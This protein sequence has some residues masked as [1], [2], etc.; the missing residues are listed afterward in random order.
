MVFVIETPASMKV[1]QYLK[2]RKGCEDEK[3]TQR[4]RH[5]ELMSK[6][7]ERK[8]PRIDEVADISKGDE[9]PPSLSPTERPKP[10]SSLCASL[11]APVEAA[12]GTLDGPRFLKK[13]LPRYPLLARR[14]GKEG[15][16]LLRLTIDEKGRLIKC[17]VVKGAGYGFE[18]AAI[19]AVKRSKFL[20]A[21]RKGRPIS[22]RALLPIKFVIRR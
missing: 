9:Q 19:K 22:C 6:K 18:E 11:G 10:Y 20:P 17:E 13:V 21:R 5:T 7:L 14:L 15:T 3:V 16:V 8:G 12:F 1:R 2:D 4:S